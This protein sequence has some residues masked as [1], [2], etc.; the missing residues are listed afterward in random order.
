MNIERLPVLTGAPR[1]QYKAAPM[2]AKHYIHREEPWKRL[3]KA[4]INEDKRQTVIILAGMAGCGKTQLVAEVLRVYD[5]G[6]N[7]Q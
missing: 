5:P 7:A 6:P 3:I 4:V 1:S 2:R